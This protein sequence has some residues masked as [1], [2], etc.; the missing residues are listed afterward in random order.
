MGAPHADDMLVI[1]EINETTTAWCQVKDRLIFLDIAKDRYFSLSDRR[2]AELSSHIVNTG[3]ENWYQ[4]P[5]FPRPSDWTEPTRSSQAINTGGF[6]IGEVARAIWVQRRVESRLFSRSLESVLD[7]LQRVLAA[8]PHNGVRLNAGGKA[9]VRAFEY[10][11]LIRT[12]ANR[13]LPRA[14][15]LALCL[16]RA[17]CRSHLVIG[18]K[19]SPFGA[20]SWVQ[21]GADVLSDSVEEVRRYH[22]ILVL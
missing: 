7:D 1:P 20:H 17:G 16:A 11:R 6:Q 10:A 13:C 3:T 18:I 22:P 5:S 14:I 15:A 12:A 19:T 8:P 21:S 9:S 4:P 2:N